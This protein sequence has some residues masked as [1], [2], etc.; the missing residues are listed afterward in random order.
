MF[1]TTKIALSAVIILATAFSASAA[2]KPRITLS[3]HIAIHQ[4]ANDMV[5]ALVQ[6][7]CCRHRPHSSAAAATVPLTPAE[8]VARKWRLPW[9]LS[10]SAFGNLFWRRRRAPNTTSATRTRRRSAS[11]FYDIHLPLVAIGPARRQ[12]ASYGVDGNST[13]LETS[14]WTALVVPL[15]PGFARR[16]LGTGGIKGNGPR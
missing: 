3:E 9:T 8:Q 1:T 15:I 12:S 7:G 13:R 4:I 2:T 14:A 16:P 11:S 5:H 6:A 10:L